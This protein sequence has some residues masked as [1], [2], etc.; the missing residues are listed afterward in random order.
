M[1][2]PQLGTYIHTLSIIKIISLGGNR[3]LLTSNNTPAMTP[4]SESQHTLGHQTSTETPAS[5]PTEIH[6]LLP[7]NNGTTTI[8]DHYQQI[9]P[10]NDGNTHS[11]YQSTTTQI[12]LDHRPALLTPPMGSGVPP[13]PQQQQYP[14][15]QHPPPTYV[16]SPPKV[17]TPCQH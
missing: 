16:S 9:L 3:H 2:V 13:P 4:S 1:C 10:L 11:P 12:V 7:D 15:P 5:T 14:P 8:D 6:N 17:R